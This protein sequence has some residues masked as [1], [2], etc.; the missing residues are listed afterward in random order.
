MKFKLS[1]V[2]LIVIVY[3]QQ[4]KAQSASS[5]KPVLFD[6]VIVAGYVDQGAF[7]N[8]A[9]PGFR[10]TKKP[11]SLMAGFLPS[12]RIKEDKVAPGATKNS[13][14]TP[15]LGLGLTAA[16]KHLAFQLPVYYNGKTAIKNGKWN[17]GVGV[18]YKF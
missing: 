14:V 3:C 9:G 15:S 1:L 13:A 2:S 16:Y 12:I 4:V 10:F 7:I 11:F 8:C 5:I 6:G 17:L 18:G